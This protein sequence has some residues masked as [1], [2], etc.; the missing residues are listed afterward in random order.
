MIF[1]VFQKKEGFLGNLG[2]PSYGIG[3]TIRIGGEM[4]FS[5][6]RV[7]FTWELSIEKKKKNVYL[8]NSTKKPHLALQFQGLVAIR[9]ID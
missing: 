2:P 4:L 5:R 3:A 7:F 1:S 8:H 9:Y 6:M